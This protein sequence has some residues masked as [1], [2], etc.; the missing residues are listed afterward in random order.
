MKW[1]TAGALLFAGVTLGLCSSSAS[2]DTAKELKVK[3]G[4]SVAVVNLA[5]PKPDCS[6]LP[7]PVALPSLREKPANGTMQMQILVSDVGATGNCPARKIPTIALIYT[8]NK[9][10]VGTDSV[11]IE[12][13]V[14]NRTTSLSYRLVVL[15]AAQPL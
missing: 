5:N 15:P 9:D 4:T 10:F 8:P 1:T 14:G 13:E 12:I 6:A 11:Q 7:G 3:S 2:A